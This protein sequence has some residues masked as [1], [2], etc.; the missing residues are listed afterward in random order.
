MVIHLLLAA[1]RAILVPLDTNA[2]PKMRT[3][4]RFPVHMADFL[5]QRQRIVPFVQL[6]T[7]AKLPATLVRFV[8]PVLL[9]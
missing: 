8:L 9:H 1:L 7:P 5:F 4:L 3:F 2:A 6:G